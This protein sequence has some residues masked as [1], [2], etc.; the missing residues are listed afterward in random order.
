LRVAVISDV[1]SNQPALETALAAIDEVGVEEV[2]CLGDV[3]GYGAQPDACADLIQQ[4]C[5]IC[6]AGNHDLAVLGGLDIATFS[7]TAATAVEWTQENASPATLEFLRGLE[8]AAARA[9]IGLFHASPSD[10]IWEYV[11]SIDQAEAGLD[12]QEQRIG[13]IGHSHIALFFTRPEGARRGEAQ[14]AQAGDGAVLGLESGDWLLNPGSVGQPRDSDPRA[15]WLELD[16][17]QW[18]AR[19][20]RVDYDI[21]TAAETILAAGLPSQLAERLA[22]GR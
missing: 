16:T 12:A 4:R 3:V 14:G 7:E 19:Y 13:L 2:W 10:P 20:H 15:A 22:V 17:E 11:L 5:D 21:A 1:H 8:P 18:T 9:G 6:L